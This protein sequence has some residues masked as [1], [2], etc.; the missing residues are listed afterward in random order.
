MRIDETPITA[1][2]VLQAL[3]AQGGKTRATQRALVGPSEVPSP[4]PT[5]LITWQP[6]E[7]RGQANKNGAEGA[8]RREAAKTGT[9]RTIPPGREW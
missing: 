8:S 4:W 5:R 3:R 6:E 7:S 2:K 1:D 9:T